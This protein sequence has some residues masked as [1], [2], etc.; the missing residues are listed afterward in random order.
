M[1]EREQ[2]LLARF[3]RLVRR[4]LV[5]TAI[6]CHGD[7]H[8][9]QALVTGADVAIIDFE[10]EPNCPLAER[11]SSGHRCGTWRACSAR[12]PTPPMLASGNKPKTNRAV[13]WSGRSWSPGANWQ[14]W[15]SA[16]FLREYLDAVDPQLI[17]SSREDLTVLLDVFVR[18]SRLPVR[19][20]LRTR[21]SWVGIPLRGLRHLLAAPHPARDRLDA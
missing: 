7:Y 9:G 2:D 3:H 16:A 11:R 1:L 15:T 21:P 5:A 20:E 10:G 14:L 13:R 4:R 18:E 8:L 12:S 17:P 19:H 6:R